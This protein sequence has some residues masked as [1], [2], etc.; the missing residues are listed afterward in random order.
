MG[1]IQNPSVT[2]LKKHLKDAASYDELT[3]RDQTPWP[4]SSYH[5][6]EQEVML[7]K[8]R[9]RKE[10]IRSLSTIPDDP[11]AVDHRNSSVILFPG[12]GAQFVGMGAKLLHIPSVK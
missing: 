3:A 10:K 7:R 2:K 9:E 6:S 4:T 1:M 11:N 5:Q 12:Q 8:S